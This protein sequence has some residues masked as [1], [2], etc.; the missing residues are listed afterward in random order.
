MRGPNLFLWL[1]RMFFGCCV[2]VESRKALREDCRDPIVCSSARRINVEA[3]GAKVN[4][5]C[6]PVDI[7]IFGIELG[8][9]WTQ[10]GRLGR[11][12]YEYDHLIMI[13]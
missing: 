12:N 8:T 5:L 6:C 10:L 4:H 7:I 11:I 13:E 2:Q 1:Q 3:I 9:T